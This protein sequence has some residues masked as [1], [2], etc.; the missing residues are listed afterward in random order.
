MLLPWA[1]SLSTVFLVPACGT[2][3]CAV[4]NGISD[5]NT[6]YAA[7]ALESLRCLNDYLSH[8]RC[9]W[10]ES[11]QMHSQAPLSLYHWNNVD[12]ESPCLPYR[13]PDQLPDGR[14][15]VHCRYNTTG[16]A[17]G[18]RDAFFFKT[19]C[20]PALTKTVSPLQHV[21]LGPPRNLSQQAVEGGGAVLKWQ[22]PPHAT[23][24]R[25]RSSLSYQVGY[26]R[27]GGQDWTEV[28]VSELELRFEA[29]SLAADCEYE[30][31]VRVREDK[32][33]WS[34]WSPLV[35]WKT[36][37]VPG[38]SNL[39]CVF[40]GQM[41]V[42]CS[43]EVKRELAEVII[44]R[45][46]YRLN[47]SLPAQW[48]SMSS[49]PNAQHSR[50]PVLRFSCSFLVSDP[51]QQ[52]QVELLPTHNT[53]EILSH[54][55]V[56][57]SP[58]VL[59]EVTERGQDWVLSWTP[60]ESSS[61]LSISYELR[62][63]STKKQERMT[64]LNFTESARSFVMHRGSLLPS[65][66]Y[67]AQVRAWAIPRPSYAGPP[68]EWTQQIE[69]TTHPAPW[70]I[71]TLI[72]I[73]IA[74]LVGI[75]FISLYFTLPA[76]RRRI[77]LWKVS[78]PTPIK[79]KV[80][81]EIMKRTP[82]TKPTLQ[83]E[84]EKTLI[85]SVQVLGKVN[86]SCYLEDC[87]QPQK[88]AKGNSP[89]PCWETAPKTALLGSPGPPDS[90][91][92]AS[93]SFSGPY[94][95]CPDCSLPEASEAEGQTSQGHF[96]FDTPILSQLPPP[97][98]CQSMVGY[99]GIPAPEDDPCKDLAPGS[100]QELGPVWDGYV[101]DPNELMGDPRPKS[102]PGFPDC[103]PPAY[104]PTP[105]PFPGGPAEFEGRGAAYPPS[106]VPGYPAGRQGLG[107]SDRRCD[108]TDY[109]RLSETL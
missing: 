39:Q 63:W 102:S 11:M 8:I 36:E 61:L 80:L 44:Y 26:R 22:D 59:V 10:T 40:D 20:P 74:V 52:L 79:S 87:S 90:P 47:Q 89:G 19:P 16:F 6:L 55:H 23:P 69:W 96:L 48:C 43:W 85:C 58:P 46:S 28:E 64:Y 41:E 15:T 95:L 66:H 2:P 49:P 68:S 32:G 25:Q 31:K 62:Y 75:I 33:L 7:S 100:S 106:G 29:G 76:C 94:I 109:V 56:Q 27:R 14:L 105:V 67:A 78:V 77:V 57:P 84:I 34:E 51:E 21:R 50:D 42:H 37:N 9:S 38:P 53:R 92:E 18:A 97:S 17:M 83:K 91:Q 54:K 108:V 103:D 35:E 13:H 72:Y 88:L 101:A 1:L 30:A 5:T 71:S 60:P 4:H 70:S 99:V 98:L 73:P 93:L 3:P 107:L 65:T 12:R 82:S 86:E 104:T 45:L 81:E 24:S